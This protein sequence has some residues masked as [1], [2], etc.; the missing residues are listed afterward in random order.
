[1]ARAAQQG[2]RVHGGRHTGSPYAEGWSEWN[3]VRC[4]IVR[5][6]GGG[7]VW[8]NRKKW[9]ATSVRRDRFAE[10]NSMPPI[11]CGMEM[12]LDTALY[13]RGAFGQ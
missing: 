4:T 12:R 1:M 5:I 13:G 9:A 3:L 2:G 10:P 11:R 7:K 8:E 6:T